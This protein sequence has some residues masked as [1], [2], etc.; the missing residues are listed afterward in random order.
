MTD[1]AKGAEIAAVVG[2]HSL[3]LL[4]RALAVYR[5][6]EK[7]GYSVNDLADF[8][9]FR[10]KA[11]VDA[12]LRT[13][14]QRCP[15]CGAALKIAPIKEPKGRGN[16]HGYKSRWFCDND[17]CAYEKLNLEKAQESIIIR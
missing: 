2:F 10:T 14:I 7:A 12:P 8:I 16:V 17:D 15:D 1:Q 6:M 11:A 3:T 13:N 9:S 4:I 5:S